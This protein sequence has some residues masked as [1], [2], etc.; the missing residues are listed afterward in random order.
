MKWSICALL[1]IVGLLPENPAA[2][3][4]NHS[5]SQGDAVV[6]TLSHTGDTA[7]SDEAYEI[8]GPGDLTAFQT[9]RTDKFGRI[10]F[11]PDRTGTWRVRAF[12][13]DGHGSDFEVEINDIGNLAQTS[14]SRDRG[15]EIPLV[16]VFVILALAAI[17]SFY[18]KKRRR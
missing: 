15:G 8:F 2:H 7:F 10:L 18:L 13:E 11:V 14:L 3:E 16:G 4:L 1:L 6:I 12:S 5:L 17:L 9:G